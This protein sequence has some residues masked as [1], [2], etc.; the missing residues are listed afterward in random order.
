[1]LGSKMWLVAKYVISGTMPII[2][3]V[4]NF[5]LTFVEIPKTVE[6]EPMNICMPGKS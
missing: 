1:M 5:M 6:S 2:I 3:D 4:T